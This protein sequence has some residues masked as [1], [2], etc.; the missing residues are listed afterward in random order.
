MILLL[1]SVFFCWLI[2]REVFK[3]TEQFSGFSLGYIA[4]LSV[5]AIAC[6]RPAYK[7]W[8]L[9]A[10]LSEKASIAAERPNVKVKCKSIFGTIAAGRGT[11][12]IAGTADI[13]NGIIN[14]E[15]N[16]CEL[17][18]DY[19][20]DPE[21]ASMKEMYAMQVFIHEVMHVRGEYNERKT[22]CQ[23]IQRHHKIS[24]LV[25][26]DRSIARRDA[27][28]YYTQTYPRHPYYTPD[29]KPKGKYD[30]RLPDSVWDN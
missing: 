4:I 5:L 29:C 23:A 10:F 22:E 27:K 28:R 7:T 26:V 24:E 15:N 6:A 8:R 17:F 18:T 9:E 1:L 12:Y 19:M 30:E 14:F 13:E 25:G 11:D 21:G 3:P 16:F 2:Y 20:N